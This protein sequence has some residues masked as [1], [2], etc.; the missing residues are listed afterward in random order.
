MEIIVTAAA[1]IVIPVVLALAGFTIRLTNKI[2]AME[3]EVEALKD[4]AAT[5]KATFELLF[6]KIDQMRDGIALIQVSVAELNG[7]IRML[8]K[9]K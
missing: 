4:Q 9:E 2:S 3:K 1:G 8:I 7:S 6:T 5:N